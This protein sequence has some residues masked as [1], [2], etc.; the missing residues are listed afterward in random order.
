MSGTQPL[1]QGSRVLVVDGAGVGNGRGIAFGVAAAGARVTIADLD[2]DRAREVAQKITERGG[3]AYPLRCDVL[4][5]ADI[6]RVTAETV[7]ALGALDCV[8]TV[9][10][11]YSLFT[12]WTPPAE[13][14]DSSGT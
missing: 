13:V 9:V 11:D 12:P 4:V 2:A 3:E 1:L 10:G 14:T 7:D 8:V 5:P 6:E